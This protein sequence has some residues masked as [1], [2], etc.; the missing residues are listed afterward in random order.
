M[1]VYL[2]KETCVPGALIR[3]KQPNIK[4]AMIYVVLSRDVDDKIMFYSKNKFF[5]HYLDFKLWDLIC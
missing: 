4:E 3:L 1:T 2:T 5:M